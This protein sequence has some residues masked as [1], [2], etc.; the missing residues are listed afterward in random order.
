M[1]RLAFTT[2]VI[3]I[4]FA[5][6]MVVRPYLEHH[7]HH[8]ASTGTG[9]KSQLWTCSM[10][11]QVLQDHSGIC[12]ICHM[13][14]TPVKSSDAEAGVVTID[15]VVVQN[16]GIR[17]A[18][19]TEGPIS[20][21]VRVVGY[22]E[23]PEPVHRDINLRVS[24]WIEKLYANIDGMDVAKDQPLFDLYSPEMMVAVDELIAARRQQEA[25]PNDTTAK[26]LYD[27][28]RR[29][30]TQY[31]L[32]A[33]QIESLA[34]LDAAPATIPILSPI[35]GHL[36][37]KMVYE[38]AAVKAGDLVMRLANRH[39]MW[40]D[41]QVFEQQYPL[42]A[43]GAKAIASVTAQPGKTYE[44]KVI[45]VHPHIDPQTR[46]ALVRIEIDNHDMQLRQG[47]YATVQIEASD[48][49]PL[50][51]VPREAVIDTGSRKL[52]FVSLGEGRFEPRELKLGLAGAQNV[53]VLSGLELGDRV[54]TSGQFLLDTESRLR[55]S[56][57]KQTSTDLLVSDKQESA[58]ESKPADAPKIDIPHASDI[59]AAYLALQQ[60]LGEK[61]KSDTPVDASA[62][63]RNAEL[64]ASH[65]PGDAKPLVAGV[66]DAAKAMQSKTLDQQREAFVKLSEATIK[67]AS[68]TRLTDKLY[69]VECPMAFG[70][71]GARWLQSDDTVANPYYATEM[72]SCGGVEATLEPTAN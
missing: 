23:E 48:T 47:M 19:V 46:S 26:T 9:E 35:Q 56:I 57:A 50:K 22:L 64:S 72:K 60:K 24:G 20:K 17:T 2:F 49:Q 51:L 1:K 41:A 29:K 34:K 43:I 44:G 63:I 8:H 10:H 11:P 7:D 5:A 28:G 14:L 52:V 37:A 58:T 30:L 12:P 53:Q 16:M 45:F 68:A 42:V 3:L 32:S 61:Q 40:I 31:G 15:P 62:L 69:V 71:K 39:Q 70:D 27:S 13:E 59:L 33:T 65:A 6:G 21:D 66:V 36:T 4:G 18:V 25:S 54:V 67:L 55:E 38:G